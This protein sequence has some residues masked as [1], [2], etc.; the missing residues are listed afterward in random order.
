MARLRNCLCDFYRGPL[1][2]LS[3]MGCKRIYW[4]NSPDQRGAHWRTFACH[5]HW[6]CNVL[7]RQRFRLQCGDSGGRRRLDPAVPTSRK[8]RPSSC[9]KSKCRLMGL[10]SGSVICTL[11][12]SAGEH[13]S[14]IETFGVIEQSVS[15]SMAGAGEVA[16]TVWL[17]APYFLQRVRTP[18]IVDNLAWRWPLWRSNPLYC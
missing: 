15:R 8:S 17:P 16:A 12:C 14:E 9:L 6:H 2:R 10:R 7:A 1:R 18:T 13:C 5:S 11:T 4:R 3:V